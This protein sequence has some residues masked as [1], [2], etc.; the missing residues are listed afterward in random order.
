M[1]FKMQTRL[2]EMINEA[3]EFLMKKPYPS[4]TDLVEPLRV[5]LAQIFGLGNE[6][7]LVELVAANAYFRFTYGSDCLIPDKVVHGE[8][9]MDR[10]VKFK[11]KDGISVDDLVDKSYSSLFPSS[12]YSEVII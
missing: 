5:H 12:R 11:L 2:K 10:V 9:G 3:F 7:K 1:R 6:S 8:P 4:K